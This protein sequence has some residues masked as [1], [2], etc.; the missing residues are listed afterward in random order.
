M[1]DGTR[2]M[3]D[4]NWNRPSLVRP[5]RSYLA[6]YSKVVAT[7]H[8]RTA[9]S[10]L[11]SSCST[12]LL[13]LTGDDLSKHND[14]VAVHEGDTREPFAVF[15]AIAD[16]RL[17]G[18]ERALRHL[19]GLQSMRILRFFSAC[20]FAHLPDDLRD[21]ACRPSAADEADRRI[22]TFDLVWDVEN[23]DLCFELLRL[24]Q[25]GILF[26]NH[27]IAGTRH[28]VLVQAFDV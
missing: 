10:L 1:V 16:Q 25:S 15:K 20:F 2:S 9:Y 24:A 28:V 4:T 5:H 27:H 6:F 18:L 21:A 12:I 7:Y 8:L 22:A 14:T 13:L 23:L 11:L 17:L 26:V 3:V 19:V